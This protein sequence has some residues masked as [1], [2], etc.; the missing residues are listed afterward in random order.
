VAALIQPHS[1]ATESRLETILERIQQL[2]L[3]TD[4]DTTR[5]IEHLQAQR[6]ELDAQIERLRSGDATTLTNQQAA[7]RALDILNLA[8]DL[9]EDFA[10]V[11]AALSRINLDLRAQ[12]IEQPSSR[13]A[14]LDNIFRGV[15]LVAESDAG[16]SF[17][18][19]YRL[20]LD[21]ER[22]AVV[23]D[24]IDALITRGFAH[25]L[26][27]NQRRDLFRLLPTMRE[28]GTEIHQ[29]M[30]AF[31]RTLRQFVR[32]EELA[33]D[34]RL[35]RI[36]RQ[37]LAQAR[38]LADTIPPTQTLRLELPLTGISTA[39]ISAL[40]LY[41]PED[42]EVASDFTAGETGV[43]DLEA[44]LEI[45]RQSE[46]D[47]GELTAAV[48]DVITTQGAATI[49]EILAV[50]PATQGAASVVGLLYLA[51]QHATLAR[52][53]VGASATEVVSWRVLDYP[54]TEISDDDAPAPNNVSN[55]AD[56]ANPS[57]KSTA[58]KAQKPP[59]YQHARISTYLFE[60]QI[61]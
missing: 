1:T 3:D 37:A 8:A 25:D 4:E 52:K 42:N 20:I 15:D 41:S 47:L 28:A 32:S 39:H 21:A 24:E 43:A 40:R 30:T 35:H 29:V 22:T 13:G 54:D 6:A 31:S 58:D 17:S 50:H 61:G 23:E 26:T 27:P 10:R 46:I 44:L 45:V 53:E 34:R 55:D 18:A 38:T 48:N 16:R 49:G 56:S 11:R 60:T 7:E 51:V 12:L 5:R 2:A 14:V 9:P 33:E 59:S 57:T 19:F 36:T